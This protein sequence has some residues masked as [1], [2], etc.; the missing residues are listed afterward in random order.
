MGPISLI[1]AKPLLEESG[2]NTSSFEFS[3]GRQF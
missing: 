1:F 2:D 3:M